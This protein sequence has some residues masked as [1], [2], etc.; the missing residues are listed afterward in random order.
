M[1]EGDY[2]SGGAAAEPL[3]VAHL[4]LGWTQAAAMRRFQDAVTRHGAAAPSGASLK[5]MRAY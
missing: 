4:R 3:K 1:T 2:D 5:R